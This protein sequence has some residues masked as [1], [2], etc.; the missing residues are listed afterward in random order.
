MPAKRKA[1]RRKPKSDQYFAKDDSEISVPIITHPVRTRVKLT[2]KRRRKSSKT[3][4]R[5]IAASTLDLNTTL[6]HDPEHF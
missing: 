5:R 6:M 4:A 3:R 1:H 2:P